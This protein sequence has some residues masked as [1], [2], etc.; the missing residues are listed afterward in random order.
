MKLGRFPPQNE[1]ETATQ[2]QE[3]PSSNPG[4]QPRGTHWHWLWT[5]KRTKASAAIEPRTTVAF[6]DVDIGK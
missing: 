6:H 2:A 5:W 3:P 1:R 4:T